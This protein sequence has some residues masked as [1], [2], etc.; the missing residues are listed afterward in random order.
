MG[1]LSFAIAQKSTFD[2]IICVFLSGVRPPMG[3]GPCSQ[4][5]AILRGGP[6]AVRRCCPSEVPSESLNPELAGPGSVD[7]P[8]QV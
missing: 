8:W 7:P 6:P 3:R 5:V 4:K 1:H 2:R